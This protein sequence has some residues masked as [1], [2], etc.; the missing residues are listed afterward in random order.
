MK[1]IFLNILVLV[2]CSF[3]LPNLAASKNKETYE[4]LDLFGQI[5]VSILLKLLGV[6]LLVSLLKTANSSQ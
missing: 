5:F 2:I 3:A 6:G 4:Y 1:K